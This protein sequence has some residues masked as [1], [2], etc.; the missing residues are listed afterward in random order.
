MNSTCEKCRLSN[1]ECGVKVSAK[2]YREQQEHAAAIEAARRAEAD[3][4]DDTGLVIRGS[5]SPRSF[6][7]FSTVRDSAKR[8][9]DTD[10][11]D[12][13]VI[14]QRIANDLQTHAVPTTHSLH[15][16]A[17]PPTRMQMP[18]FEQQPNVERF[19]TTM[20]PGTFNMSQDQGTFP[21]G[22]APVP[23]FS[24][25]VG[26]PLGS[27]QQFQG[28]FGGSQMGASQPM[29]PMH[30]QEWPWWEHSRGPRSVL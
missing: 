5:P 28:Q 2:E 4:R 30:P 14:I 23:D 26:T 18:I 11:R 19:A 12:P 1:L 24:P 17:A 10:E 6:R 15:I 22:G 16:V 21:M 29:Q 3:D 9:L 20:S 27:T 13:E 8:A 25:F 7:V